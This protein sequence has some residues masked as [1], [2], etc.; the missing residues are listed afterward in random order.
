M[1][2]GRVKLV[3][4]LLGLAL[5]VLIP[6]FLLGEGMMARFGGSGEWLQQYGR[7]TGWLVGLGLLVSDL[8]LPVP[9][10]AVISALG[11]VYGALQGAA[12]GA[13]G[14]FL[15]GSLAYESC[16]AGG[17]RVVEWLLGPED[18]VK[19]GR[20]FAGTSGGWLVALSRWLP[21]L[22]EM[23]CCM[24][25]L[26]RMARRRFYTALACGCGPMALTFATI[27]STGTDR[28]GLALA[29]SALAPAL[30]YG[31]AV[32]WL[33]RHG[34]SGEAEPKSAAEGLEEGKGP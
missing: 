10:T 12:I 23:S 6:F 28:P 32:W 7:N 24:A 8:V 2:Y 34:G 11:F 20:I 29:L 13:A 27:G 31:L 4:L 26:T 30:L 25:G 17:L 22:P 9:A 16:R 5:L 15:S 1:P 14:S 18:R 3:W 21:L 19:A 33:K